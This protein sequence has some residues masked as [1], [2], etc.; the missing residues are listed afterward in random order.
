MESNTVP[1]TKSKEMLQLQGLPPLLH[2]AA[3]DSGM[4]NTKFL[5]AIGNG[6]PVNVVS[7]ILLKI[8]ESMG[9]NDDMEMEWREN[10]FERLHW[11]SCCLWVFIDLHYLLI[12]ICHSLVYH[13][14]HLR[15]RH[16]SWH[17]WCS[18]SFCGCCC[19]GVVGVLDSRVLKHY[20]FK[21]NLSTLI[22]ATQYIYIYYFIYTP[23]TTLSLPFLYLFLN[24]A[25]RSVEKLSFPWLLPVIFYPHNSSWIID[26]L[27]NI[28][29]MFVRQPHL[30]DNIF[31]TFGSKLFVS[32]GDL[33]FDYAKQHVVSLF[34]LKT[35]LYFFFRMK[36]ILLMNPWIH[37]N[38]WFVIHTGNRF[39]CKLPNV[40]K[41]A[42]AKHTSF[43]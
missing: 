41:I 16:R 21:I 3:L 2:T 15:S 18:C 11:C 24:A 26:I 23:L 25:N 30:I 19:L 14:R 32:N 12:F 43:M 39:S 17:W 27:L 38:I 6:W 29:S 5:G 40:D 13:S 4:S 33:S 10:V 22:K 9:W 28:F 34:L 8:K 36:H 20:F 42:K 37:L 31:P 1:A 35:P 7:A